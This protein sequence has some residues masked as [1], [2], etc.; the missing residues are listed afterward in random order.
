MS[1]KETRDRMVRAAA[2]IA[3]SLAE[4]DSPLASELFDELWPVLL[5]TWDALEESQ[6]DL[7]EMKRQVR[8]HAEAYREEAKVSTWLATKMTYS[9]TLVPGT[10]HPGNKAQEW[11][12]AARQAVQS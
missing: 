6:A 5:A 11:L 7:E 4:V 9:N 3:G 10:N 12:T 1:A 8:F 2:T